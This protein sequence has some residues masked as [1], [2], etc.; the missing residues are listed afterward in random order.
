MKKVKWAIIA[1]LIAL[2]ASGCNMLMG[3]DGVVYGK[4][5]YD[6]SYYIEGIW[7]YSG[8]SMGFPTSGTFGTYYKIAPGTYGFVY[9]LYDYYYYYG[10]YYD[11]SD[12][13][14]VTYTVKANEGK[15]FTD[16]DDKYFELYL[17]WY[18]YYIYGMNTAGKGK[19][20]PEGD[21][22]VYKDDAVT[23]TASFKPMKEL[24]AGATKVDFAKK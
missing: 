24:P 3:K 23:V 18:N 16:G 15:L 22:V 20:A 7:T 11:Y 6:S 2:S 8:M 21:V 12:Y 5:T 4:L 1:V 9:Q 14:Y 13:I 17:G 10:Y 19:V